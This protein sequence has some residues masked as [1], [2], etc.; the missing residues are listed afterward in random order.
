LGKGRLGFAVAACALFV[1]FGVAA[2]GS[3]DNGGS[4]TSSADEQQITQAIQAAATS[5]D[6]SACT[7]YQTQRFLEQTN[8]GT[9]QAAVRS[10]E[11]DAKSTA[12]NSID[13]SDVKVNGDH[14][15]AVGKATGSIFDGQTLK[16]ALVKE[17]GQW[18]LDDFQG[19]ENF[20]KDAMVAAFEKQ[21]SAQNVPQQGVD[22]LKQQFQSASDQ[23]IEDTFVGSNPQAE[24]QLFGPC[25]KYFQGQ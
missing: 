11:N 22:C 2:C 6:P 18:K 1:S 7:K 5:G 19:F 15:T 21:L 16:V 23:Q 13:V 14:A 24:N 17:N 9:G 4:S 25:A 3:S 8:S 10:C 20:N 12:A